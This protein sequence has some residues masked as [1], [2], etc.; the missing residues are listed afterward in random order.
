M[1][2]P[3]STARFYFDHDADRRLAEALRRRGFDVETAGDLGRKADLDETQ[4]AYASSSR[5]I[6]VTHNVHHFPAIHLAWLH[7]GRRHSGIVVLIGYP[8]VGVWLSRL[9]NLLVMLGATELENGIVYLGAEFDW[10]G[11]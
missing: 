4:L 11:I 3:V 8:G 6:F 9:E 5:R 2:S 1:S 7:S 10:P